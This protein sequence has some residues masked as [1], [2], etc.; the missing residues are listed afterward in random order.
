LG[1]ISEGHL[2]IRFWFYCDVGDKIQDYNN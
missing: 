1:L 2:F